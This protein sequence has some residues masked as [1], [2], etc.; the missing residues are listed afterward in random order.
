MNWIRAIL[1]IGTLIFVAWITFSFQIWAGEYKDLFF[2]LNDWKS[3]V[4]LTVFIF[5]LGGIFKWL[6]MEEVK[7]TKP[8]EPRRGARR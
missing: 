5:A 1:I 4:M 7:L 8:R 2:Y 6:L 3:W